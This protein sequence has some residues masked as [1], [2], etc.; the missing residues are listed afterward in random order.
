MSIIPFNDRPEVDPGGP[1]TV[2]SASGGI[3]TQ[4]IDGFRQGVSVRNMS[5]FSKMMTPYIS[6][7][8]IPDNAAKRFDPHL[9]QLNFGHEI[10]FET[11][12]KAGTAL[13]PFDDIKGILSP[14]EFI[15]DPMDTQYPVVMMS[16]NF[17]DPA[18]MNGVI[19]PLQIRESLTNA[20]IGGPF[21]AHDIRGA[22]MPTVGP[23]I[24]G[25]GT[26]I[27][28][29]MG[30]EPRDTIAPYFDSQ[31]VSLSMKFGDITFK[32]SEEGYSY[33]EEKPIKP[34]NDAINTNPTDFSFLSLSGSFNSL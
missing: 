22:L 30:F 27:S 3:D 26:I 19:E 29:F 10:L 18:M 23:E 20:A 25:R 9:T 5:D 6:D 17:L 2:I 32:L 15:N 28:N 21:I 31:N 34:F 1:N 12:N 14:V 33:P 13:A 7:R 16:P 11:V 8:G 4:E 24:A